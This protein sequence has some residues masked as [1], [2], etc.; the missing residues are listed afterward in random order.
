MIDDRTM[1]PIPHVGYCIYERCNF[2]DEAVQECSGD[3]FGDY[4]PLE[5]Q[6]QQ[7][8]DG[9]CTIYWTEDYD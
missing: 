6:E 3:C 8:F 5:M 1:C 7:P 9:P 4:E 2:W